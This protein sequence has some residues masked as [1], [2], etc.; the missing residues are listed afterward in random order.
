MTAT[1]KAD[2]GTTINYELHG[3]SG[4]ETLVLLPGLLGSL[5]TQWQNF[6]PLLTP[7]YQILVMDL[8]G[9]GHSDN[10]APNLSMDRM[11]L[12]VAGL[13]DH[14]K[15]EA[16]HFTGYSLGGYL[17]L[18]LYLHEP[19][20]VMTLM[21]H[22]TKFYWTKEAVAKM[23]Q[24][25]DPDTMAEKVPNYANQLVQEHGGRHWR[26]LVRQAA[27][28]V[29]DLGKNGLTESM[30]ARVR[31]PVVVSVGDRDELIPLPEALRLS[32]VLP[33]ANLMVLPG[34]RHPYASIKRIPLLP[35][36]QDFH[37]AGAH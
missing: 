16:A 37:R 28:L 12:D 13:M 29:A 15:I 35:V 18:M 5:N 22:A 2:D 31:C 1:W 20:R 8:R 7:Q 9:H 19:R 21:M 23:H 26:V 24:Q 27:D 11:V 10:K 36:M 6:I 33:Q 30:V 25:L 34:V 14:L 32:R 17:G 4:K 3:S